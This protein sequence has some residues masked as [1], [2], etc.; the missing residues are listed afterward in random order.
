M[1]NKEVIQRV[2]SAYSRGVQSDDTRLA[3]RLI[4]NKLITLRSKVLA[5][6][7]DKK[8]FL[9]QWN[10]QSLSCI[11]MVQKPVHECP[12]IPPAGCFMW[13]SKYKIPEPLASNNGHLIQYVS[14]LNGNIIF[15]ETKFNFV[16]YRKGNKYTSQKNEFFIE[17]DYLW[18]ITKKNDFGE[19]DMFR[20]LRMSALFENPL[21]VEQFIDFCKDRT[22]TDCPPCDEDCT[23]YPDRPFPLDNDFIEKIV[24]MS[25]EELLL[26]PAKVGKEDATAD[27]R[28]NPSQESK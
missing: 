23:S 9:S 1:L 19:D 20:V 3:P 10:Y 7:K 15:D 21:T 12:C 11:E 5:E 8:Q 4:Y 6:A 17:S 2:Q 28:D 26:L 16:K 14:N 25:F 18:I 24:T 27:T 13:R 22:C